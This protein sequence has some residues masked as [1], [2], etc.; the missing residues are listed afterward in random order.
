MGAA[1]SAAHNAQAARRAGLLSPLAPGTRQLTSACHVLSRLLLAAG[2]ILPPPMDTRLTACSAGAFVHVPSSPQRGQ[3]SPPHRMQNSTGNIRS[4]CFHHITQNQ[5][6]QEE[7]NPHISQ[8]R[9]HF[10]SNC[11]IIE[12]ET[13]EVRFLPPVC[14]ETAGQPG[15]GR[16]LPKTLRNLRCRR[17]TADLKKLKKRF[18]GFDVL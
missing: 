13:G 15:A 3:R 16:L 4:S 1:G 5:E 12:R 7:I 9:L 8:K 17:S 2:A 14:S 10:S 6:V 18:P 11:G